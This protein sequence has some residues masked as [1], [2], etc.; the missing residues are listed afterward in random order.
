MVKKRTHP[1]LSWLDRSPIHLLHRASQ[2]VAE[3]F[4]YRLG[5]E[6]TPRQLTVLGEVARQEG[7]SQTRLVERTG[8]DRTTISDIVKRMQSKG[9]LHRSRKKKDTR[10]YVIK[11]TNDGRRLLSRVDPLAKQVDEQILSAVPA[12]RAEEFLS[13]LRILAETTPGR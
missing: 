11:L 1:T 2:R 12:A 8:V 7:L 4:A 9:W 6:V 5:G 10:A 13:M 3:I